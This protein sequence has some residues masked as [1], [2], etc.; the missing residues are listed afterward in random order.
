MTNENIFN[1]IK[2]NTGFTDIEL[3]IVL[4]H[5]ETKNIKKKTNL[6]KAGTTA[7]EIYFI[8]TGSIRLFYEKNGE[9]ISAYFFTEEMFA[10]AYDSFISQKISRHSIETSEDCNVLSIS[11]ETFQ[12]LLIDF[13]KMNEFVR[14]VLEE[15]FVS[16]HELFT[17]Q[18]LDSPE[19][20]YLN[21]QKERPDLL[22]RIP[23]H[24]IATFL[25]ITPVSLS[26]IRNRIT[27]K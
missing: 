9:D 12:K 10:G 23:Q 13:P 21:L 22:Q 19:E 17:S 15:R 1:S 27:K 6:L 14:K 24:Q 2:K 16:L 20:R 25:G 8:L 26:R 5:F 7:K 4:K 11:Y 18:I 3:G